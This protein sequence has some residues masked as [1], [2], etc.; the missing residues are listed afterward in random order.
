M[1][2]NVTLLLV[3][4]ALFAGACSRPVPTVPTEHR[5]RQEAWDPELVR[6][7]ATLP[8]QHDGRVK[9]LGVLAAFTLYAVHG[10]RDLQFAWADADAGEKVTLTPTEWLLDVLCYPDQAADYPLFRIENRQVLDAIGIEREGAQ[11]MDFDY[12]SYQRLLQ[13]GMQLEQ[14][15]GRIEQIDKRDRSA[16]DRQLWKLIGQLLDYHGLH[17][18]LAPLQRPIEVQGQELQQAL[19]GKQELLF[20]EL[21]ARG[22]AFAAFVRAHGQGSDPAIGNALQIA[23]E[24]EETARTGSFLAWFPPAP[25]AAAT[26][27]WGTI[28]ELVEPAMR[29]QLGAADQELLTALQGAVAAA[30]PDEL[31]TSLR[32]AHRL[33]TARAQARGEAATVALEARYY[34]WSLHYKSLHAGFLPAFLLVGLL[35][36]WPRSRGLWLGAYAFTAIGFLLVAGDV[37]LRCIIRGRPPITGLYDTFLFITGVG[38]LVA[39]ITEAINRRRVALSIAPIFGAVL[40]MLARMFEV[41]DGKDTME[42]L[43]AVLDSNYWLATHVTSINT[44]YAAGMVAALL[45]TTWLLVGALGI[46]RGD[47]AFHK[48]IVR[49]TYGATCFGLL[50]AVVGTIL[51]GVWANDSWGRFWG[52]DTK[53]NGALLICISQIALLHARMSG[54]VRDLGFCVWAGLTGCVVA[55]SWFH[56]NQLLVVSGLHSYGF[57]EGTGRAL[58]IYYST[59]IG[60]VLL[61]TAGRL[62]RAGSGAPATAALGTP[63]SAAK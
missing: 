21:L 1:N 39:L 41:A 17:Q 11:R 20:A 62:L 18:L 9:P 33:A 16:E 46:K 5:A 26:D 10:R 47:A 36:L 32:T 6:L 56:V 63:V 15:R 45:G 3:A 53:E 25:G 52:W 24:L 48:S 28:G 27:K 37:L 4:A 42:P 55:F 50:F 8:V 2:R 31:A 54:L 19:G 58:A 61:G 13:Q 12:L 43:Q 40:V 49:M 38:V 34:D 22:S 30:T 60:L 44:G 7:L 57:S 14:A 35:W 29:G 23:Q 51:G 59:Q